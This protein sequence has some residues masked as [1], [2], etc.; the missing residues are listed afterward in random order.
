MSDPGATRRDTPRCSEP[1][2][3]EEGAG[4]KVWGYRGIAGGR[5]APHRRRGQ[6]RRWGRGRRRAKR[7]LAE[8]TGSR[9]RWRGYPC[10]WRANRA[11]QV[12]SPGLAVHAYPDQRRCRFHRCT[13][14][15]R[16]LPPGGWG[17]PGG[18]P[19]CGP[20]IIGHPRFRVGRGTGAEPAA[21]R[22]SSRNAPPQGQPGSAAK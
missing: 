17:A 11:I 19:S 22:R 7:A 20:C 9:R 8:G 2:T 4:L 15:S 12:T 6:V 16:G 10:G 1:S 21:V 18:T 5:A 13:G 3:G 14:G